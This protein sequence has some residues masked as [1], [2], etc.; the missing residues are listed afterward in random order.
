M[1]NA[2][3][4]TNPS[5]TTVHNGWSF[6]PIAKKV[7]A[8]SLAQTRGARILTSNWRS[9]HNLNRPGGGHDC[10]LKYTKSVLMFA[11]SMHTNHDQS[12]SSTSC[13]RRGSSDGVPHVRKSDWMKPFSYFCI[14]LQLMFTISDH[15]MKTSG[16]KFQIIIT[17]KHCIQRFHV[18]LF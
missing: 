6:F 1:W 15:F 2:S 11:N 13:R 16:R 17:T 18:I 5:T 10:Q 4:T 9:L 7:K 14:C 12:I 8:Y 3:K